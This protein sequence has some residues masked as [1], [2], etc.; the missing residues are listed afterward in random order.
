MSDLV[1]S[2]KNPTQASYSSPPYV[3]Y[4]LNPV[5]ESTLGK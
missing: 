1:G 4:A 5:P 2:L 3:I